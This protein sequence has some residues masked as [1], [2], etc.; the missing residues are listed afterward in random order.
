MDADWSVELGADDPALEFPW[1]SPDGTEGYV[2]LP[3]RLN[4]LYEVMEAAANHELAEFLRTVNG[5]SSQWL[6]AKCDV[7]T[8]NELG[9]AEAVYDATLKFACYVDLIAREH[10][11]RFSFARHEAWVKSVARKLDNEGAE[12]IACE[13]VV[14]RCWFHPEGTADPEQTD[15]GFYVTFYLFGYG[16]DE[17]EARAPWAEGLRRV[18]DVLADLTV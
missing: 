14:R 3:A 13:L 17:A 18:T 4:G 8:D 10:P 11:A 16:H 2:D 7:W 9:E 12:S 15:A 6:T 5:K 1:T